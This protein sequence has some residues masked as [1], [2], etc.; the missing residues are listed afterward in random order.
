VNDPSDRASARAIEAE[1]IA[2]DAEQA[3]RKVFMR[4]F[5]E[6]RLDDVMFVA[7][8]TCLIGYLTG[9][10]EGYA[11]KSGAAAREDGSIMRALLAVKEQSERRFDH[12]PPRT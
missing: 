4:A 10:L 12:I 8:L 5:E 9:V 3:A 11:K 7:A 6:S 1:R 2:G